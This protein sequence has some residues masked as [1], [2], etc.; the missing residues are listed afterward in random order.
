MTSAIDSLYFYQT[1]EMFL[2]QYKEVK[3]LTVLDQLLRLRLILPRKK[4]QA[5]PFL[6]IQFEKMFVFKALAMKED[7]E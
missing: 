3:Y 4:V 6:Q 1:Q 2:G 5:K 7:Q